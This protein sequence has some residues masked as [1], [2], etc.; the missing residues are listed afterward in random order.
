[1]Y[2]KRNTVIGELGRRVGNYEWQP[3]QNYMAG[4]KKVALTEI[5]RKCWP[6]RNNRGQYTLEKV[7]VSF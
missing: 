5:R 4:R 7:P 2:V 6:Q 1:M 3:H